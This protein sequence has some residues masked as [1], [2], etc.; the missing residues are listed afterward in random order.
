MMQPHVPVDPIDRLQKLQ[1]LD[2]SQTQSD[3]LQQHGAMQMAQGLYGIQ[4]EQQML[5]EQLKALAASTAARQFETEK[6]QQ[7]LPEQLRG[8]RAENAG[9]EFQNQWAQP[10][11]E[12][13]YDLKNAQA[14][15]IRAN[16]EATRKTDLPDPRMLEYGVQA[17]WWKPEDVVKTLPGAYKGLTDSYTT[18]LNA[19]N[20]EK[21]KARAEEE[22]RLNPTTPK[23]LQI[24]DI[25][26][27]DPETNRMIGEYGKPPSLLDNLT[28]DFTHPQE[29]HNRLMLQQQQDQARDAV[30]RQVHPG[31]QFIYD[32]LGNM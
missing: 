19:E 3:L 14:D 1:N 21:A 18:R 31:I 29:A 28:N 9:R 16:A 15:N 22:N 27:G 2:A 10:N 20:A 7:E 13:E 23:Q 25:L 4:H 6:G 32:M 17:G 12:A 5:P 8:M 24:P 30:R 26:K 11:A